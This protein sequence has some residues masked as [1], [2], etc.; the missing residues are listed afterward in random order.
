MVR[1]SIQANTTT[2]RHRIVPTPPVTIPAVRIAPDFPDR[3][4]PVH[5]Q[6][7]RIRS[8]SETKQTTPA[9]AIRENISSTPTGN[10]GEIIVIMTYIIDLPENAFSSIHVSLFS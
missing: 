7:V 10:R 2:T 5:A 4:N 6:T 1:N 9:W 8:A 3:S